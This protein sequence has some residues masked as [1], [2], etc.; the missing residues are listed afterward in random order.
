MCIADSLPMPC[1]I[2]RSGAVLV[3]NSACVTQAWMVVNKLSQNY[4]EQVI[5]N[6]HAVADAAMG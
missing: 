4:I 6:L 1:P 3:S 2:C 5:N